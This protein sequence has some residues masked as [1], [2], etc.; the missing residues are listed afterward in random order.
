MFGIFKNLMGGQ[1]DLSEVVAQ[2]AIVLDVRTVAEYNQGHGNPSKNI[3]LDQVAVNIDEIKS[4]G[5]PIITCCASGMRS[6][7]AAT[8]LNNHG[9]EAYNGGPWHK[10]DE[11]ING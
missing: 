3:P 4:W 5:K 6:G 11:L 9:I 8:I 1:A 10:A 7:T 2:G